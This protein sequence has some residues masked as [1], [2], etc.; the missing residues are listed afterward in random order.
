M[1]TMER[2]LRR[3]MMAESEPYDHHGEEGEEEES[4]A[5]GVATLITVLILILMT[6]GFERVKIWIEER[7]HKTFEPVVEKDKFEWFFKLYSKLR[8][9]EF[10]H[11]KCF[12]FFNVFCFII[13]I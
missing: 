4:D 8:T 5:E 1:T 9:E 7:A 2:A 11:R 10:L 6:I 3:I 13:F 12:P